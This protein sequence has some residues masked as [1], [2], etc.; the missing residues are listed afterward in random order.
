MWATTP[1]NT[2]AST[3]DEVTD[4]LLLTTITAVTSPF[5]IMFKR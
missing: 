3:S 2:L 1:H 5:Q 4:I